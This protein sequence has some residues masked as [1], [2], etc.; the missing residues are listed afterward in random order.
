MKLAR[1][2]FLASWMLE[3]FTSGTDHD[4]VIGDLLEEYRAGRSAGWYWWQSGTAIMNGFA[5]RFR[6]H[7][8]AFS[9]AVLWSVI[10]R[11]LPGI[12]F[13]HG[14]G[15]SHFMGSIY[16]L[17]WPYSTILSLGI[18]FGLDILYLWMGLVLSLL[19]DSLA[20][21]KLHGRGMLGG[22]WVGLLSYIPIWTAI[23]FL[24]IFPGHRIDMRHVS[25]MGLLLDPKMMLYRLPYLLCLLF[26]LWKA[27]PRNDRRISKRIS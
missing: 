9:F 18:F 1:P 26:S 5:R 21:R 14:I 11:S 4:P 15:N 10:P 27:L 17:D 23:A 2:P 24:P 16:S 13:L 7:W 6:R 19:V 20:T 12:Y 8:L 25:N 3:R 22:M